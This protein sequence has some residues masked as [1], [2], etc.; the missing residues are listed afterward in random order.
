MRVERA[1]PP[2]R[3]PRT[4]G[5][6][7]AMVA[8]AGQPEKRKK[9]VDNFE[10]LQLLGVH[11]IL[12]LGIVYDGATKTLLISTTC[13]STMRLPRV[14]RYARTASPL[15]GAFPPSHLVARSRRRAASQRARHSRD[16]L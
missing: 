9:M 10:F 16:S 4:I 13:D 2:P 1:P 11:M 14:G 15:P 12:L 8:C 6:L 7:V 5:V 3:V